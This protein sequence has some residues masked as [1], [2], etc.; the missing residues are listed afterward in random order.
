ML[1]PLLLKSGVQFQS[2]LPVR[3]ATWTN[4]LSMCIAYDFNPRSP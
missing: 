3:G 2:A 1:L 4:T